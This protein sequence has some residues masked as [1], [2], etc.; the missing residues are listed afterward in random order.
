MEEFTT[1]YHT[2]DKAGWAYCRNMIMTFDGISLRPV[3]HNGT[4]YSDISLND[5]F[6]DKN[7]VLLSLIISHTCDMAGWVWRGKSRTH[8]C[9][10]EST[11]SKTQKRK[12]ALGIKYKLIRDWIR[13]N[14]SDVNRGIEGGS[15]HL[16]PPVRIEVASYR[17][18][19]PSIPPHRQSETI[20][21]F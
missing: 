18:H 8:Y 10:I 6:I 7:T 21:S 14:D 11:E 16:F 1:W 15:K 20:H 5:H 17:R 2:C 19:Y 9:L 4:N 3:S 13:K 12:N